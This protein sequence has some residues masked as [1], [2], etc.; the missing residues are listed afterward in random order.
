MDAV[1]A[2]N[3]LHLVRL[4]QVDQLQGLQVRSVTDR[5]AQQSQCGGASHSHVDQLACAASHQQQVTMLT[6]LVDVLHVLVTAAGS[7]SSAASQ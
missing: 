2:P 4:W 5:S 6:W 1:I 7:W 3:Q